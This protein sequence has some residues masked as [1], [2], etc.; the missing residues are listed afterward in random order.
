MASI[1]GYVPS[2]LPAVYF[3]IN[4]STVYTSKAL[5]N[6][7]IAGATP[8]RTPRAH[9]CR[10]DKRA[11]P[12]GTTARLYGGGGGCFTGP[13]RPGRPAGGVGR[14]ACRIGGTNARRLGRTR[15]GVPLLPS[16]KG[17][18]PPPP[19]VP[20]TNTRLRAPALCRAAGPLRGDP[21]SIPERVGL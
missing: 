10:V 16:A 1:T 7:R 8:L 18:I 5:A 13:D 2:F 9:P 15:P 19:R 6:L 3:I 11:Q 20:R 14:S 4:R 12:A 17:G 21:R